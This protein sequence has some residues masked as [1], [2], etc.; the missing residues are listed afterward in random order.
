[1]STSNQYPTNSTNVQWQ[2]A[3]HDS[4]EEP[5]SQGRRR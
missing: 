5:L 3:L 2:F 4:G 1:M